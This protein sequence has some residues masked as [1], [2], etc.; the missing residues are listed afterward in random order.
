MD[1][2]SLQHAVSEELEWAAH[3]DASRVTVE[4]HDG[5]VRLGGLVGSLAEKHAAERVV[6]HVRGVRGLVDEIE[7]RVEESRRHSDQEIAARVESVLRWDARLPDAQ[8]RI[9]VEGGVVTLIGMLDRPYQKHDAETLVRQLEGVVAVDNRITVRAG[10]VAAD[11]AAQ[12]HRAL[13]RHVELDA[14]GIAVSTEGPTVVLMGQV[15]S[16]AARRTA[17]NAAWSAPG[18]AAV[19]NQLEVAP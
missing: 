10:T 17:E 12:V 18:V 16:L 19:E 6:W 15:R 2:E 11:I 8:L 4:V 7:V 13:A 9:K 3:V 1:D 5:I 14:G